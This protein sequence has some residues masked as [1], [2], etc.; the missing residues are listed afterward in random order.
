[1]LKLRGIRGAVVSSTTL[2]LGQGI[3]ARRLYDFQNDE[4]GERASRRS[5]CFICKF[6]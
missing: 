2:H 5:P 4:Q 3:P 6:N 1:V